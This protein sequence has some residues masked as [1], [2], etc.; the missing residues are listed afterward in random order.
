MPLLSLIHDRFVELMASGGEHMDWSAIGKLAQRDAR[1]L[2][3]AA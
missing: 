1:M 2:D 3:L